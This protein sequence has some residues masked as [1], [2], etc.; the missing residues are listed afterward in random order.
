MAQSSTSTLPTPLTLLDD[1]SS[2]QFIPGQEVLVSDAKVPTERTDELQAYAQAQGLTLRVVDDDLILHDED[3]NAAIRIVGQLAGNDREEDEEDAAEATSLAGD[4]NGNGDAA[5]GG[6]AGIIAVSAPQASL[7]EVAAAGAAGSVYTGSGLSGGSEPFAFSALS[8]FGGVAGSLNSP[9]GD[10]SIYAGGGD[11]LVTGGPGN[12][13][14]SGGDGADTLSGGAGNDSLFGGAGDDLLS[15]GAGADTIS[16]GDGADTLS[17]GAGNDLLDGGAGN[18]QLSGGAG[19][20]SLSGGDGDDTLYGGPGR[21]LLDGGAG[22]DLVLGGGDADTLYG[23]TGNDVLSGGA[24]GDSLSGGEGSDTLHG[25][26]DADALSGGAGNDALSGG[27]GADTMLGGLG[28]DVLYGGAG[29]DALSGG[30]GD[31][32]V[33][34]GDDADVLAG[35]DGNDGL[36]GGQGADT[37]SGG[38][39]AD[40]LEGA[41]GR[42]VLYGG[43]GADTISGGAEADVLLGGGD[44]DML[45]GGDGNDSLTGAAGS[46]ILAGGAG[47]DMLSG[48]AGA[49]TLLS[50]AGNDVLYGGAEDDVL[51]GGEGGDGLAGGSGNDT[52]SG[53]AGADVLSG[54]I[55]HDVLLG[56][57]GQ[58]F[59][60]GGDGDDGLQG[61]G[62]ADSLFG[63]AGNDTLSGGDG[64]DRLQGAV[65]A[66]VLLGG[67]GADTLS[68]GD[69]GDLLSGGAGGDRLLGGDGADTL[70]GGLGSDTLSGGDGDDLLAGGE[71]ADA[72]DGGA[73]N[74][75]LAGG[76]GNDAFVFHLDAA[77]GQDTITD[78]ERGQDRI[79]LVG[80]DVLAAVADAVANQTLAGGGLEISIAGETV[81]LEGVASELTVADFGLSSFAISAD[82]TS[83]E[84]GTDQTIVYTITRGGDTTAAASVGIAFAGSA[85]AGEHY[86]SPGAVTV[87]FAAGETEKTVTLTLLDDQVIQPDRDITATLVAPEGGLVDAASASATTEILDDD[88]VGS[89]GDDTINGSDGSDTLSGGDGDD[90]I[91]GGDGDDVIYGGAGNDSISG[92]AGNDSVSAGDG[93]DL[94]S[95]GDGS[96]TL[97]GGL[98]DDQIGG[99][100]GD[101]VI[102]GGAGNDT[103]AG[104]GGNDTVLGGDG[105]DLLEGG[106]GNDTL[107][108]GAGFDTVLGHSGDDLLDGGA[109]GDELVGG[110]G[111]D[112][113]LGRDGADTLSGGDGADTLSGGEGADLVDGAQ[114]ADRLFGGG[115]ADTLSGAAGDDSLF[116]GGGDDLLIGGAGNDTFA[117]DADGGNDSIADFASGSDRLAFV[118]SNPDGLAIAAYESQQLVGDAV[119]VDVGAAVV[120]ILGRT[121]LLSAADFGLSTF[122]LST[123]RTTANEGDGT[124]VTYTITRGGDVG[125]SASVDLSFGGTAEAGIDYDGSGW[126]TGVQF[127]AGE[128]VKAVTVLLLDDEASD[129]EKTLTATI[130]NAEGGVLEGST[131]VDTVIVDDDLAV[132]LAAQSLTM[133]EA[134]GVG[135]LVFELTEPVAGD[136]VVRFTVGTGTGSTA[137]AGSDFVGYSGEVTIPGGSLSADAIVT[138]LDDLVYEGN[139]QFSVSITEVIGPTGVDIG[140]SGAVNTVTIVENEAAPVL[141]VDG[142]DLMMEDGSI[143]SP[144]ITI[145]KSGATDV[146]ATVRVVSSDGS[147]DQVVSFAAGESEKTLMYQPADNA[148]ADGS[149]EITISLVDATG[150]SIG[151]SHTIQVLDDE[152]IG[153]A[154]TDHGGQ[155]PDTIVGTTDDDIIRI[156]ATA[157]IAAIS[158]ITILPLSGTDY[159]EL[160]SAGTIAGT[161]VTDAGG[162]MVMQL[163][164]TGGLGTITNT[165]VS[166]GDA[167]DIVR[168]TASVGTSGAIQQT[169][170]DM[171]DGHNRVVLEAT[172]GINS[173][174]NG[175]LGLVEQLQVTAGSG[176]DRV[177]VSQHDGTVDHGAELARMTGIDLV[178]GDGDNTIELTQRNFQGATVYANDDQ[179]TSAATIADLTVTTG[180]GTDRVI[181]QQSGVQGSGGQF[182]GSHG[183][184]VRGGDAATLGDVEMFLGEG[185]DFWRHSVD[186]AVARNGS[187]VNSDG[188]TLNGDGGAAGTVDGV[189]VDFGNGTDRFEISLHDLSGG[190]GAGNGGRNGIMLSG[191]HG[192]GAGL[193]QASSVEFG[194]DGYFSVEIA[195]AAAGSGGDGAGNG[196]SAG[197]AGDAGLVSGLGVVAAGGL[198]ATIRMAGVSGGNS[199]LAQV[200]LAS[201]PAGAKHNGGS[202]GVVSDTSFSAGAG[203]APTR[204]LV[205]VTVDQA[206]GGTGSSVNGNHINSGSNTNNAGSGGL[207][208][209]VSGLDVNLAAADD[210][211][212]IAVTRSRGG[213]GGDA[214]TANAG[215]DGPQR[216]GHGGD[217]GILDQT[218]STVS[219]GD[220]DDLISIRLADNTG[221]DAGVR[222]G[223]SPTTA[224]VEMWGGSAGVVRG[225]NYEFG[226]GN[227]VLDVELTGNAV[228]A[229]RSSAGAGTAG[230]LSGLA[231]NAGDGADTLRFDISGNMSGSYGS[232]GV[233]DASSFDLGG[234]DDRL[235]IAL[236]GN[237]A[238]VDG[239]TRVNVIK[240]TT[241]VAGSGNDVV[242]LVA[243]GVA[244]TGSASVT[245]A[246]DAIT[247]TSVNLGLGADRIE[248]DAASIS[249]LSVNGGLEGSTRDTLAFVGQ[250]SNVDLRTGA[251]AL[252]MNSIEQVDLAA[253]TGSTL[254]LGRATVLQADPSG[255]GDRVL[256][257]LGEGDDIVVFDVGTGTLTEV[258]TIEEAGVSYRRFAH[259]QSGSTVY[260]ETQQGV[261]VNPLGFEQSATFLDGLDDGEAALRPAGPGAGWG[262]KPRD[263]AKIDD[264]AGMDARWGGG[265]PVTIG[266]FFEPGRLDAEGQA[267]FEAAVDSWLAKYS[268]TTGLEFARYDA[269][270]GDT[271]HDNGADIAVGIG[272]GYLAGIVGSDQV[273][274]Y[275]GI[276]MGLDPSQVGISLGNAGLTREHYA[277]A[278]GDIFLHDGLAGIGLGEGSFG[279]YVIGQELYHSLGGGELDDAALARLGLDPAAA[280]LSTVADET[281]PDVTAT[282]FA[283]DLSEFD[284]AQLQRL[285]GVSDERPGAASIA[286][287]FRA[288]EALAADPVDDDHQ[289]AIA[290]VA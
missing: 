264:L 33:L 22:N 230:T 118:G 65:G 162:A 87:E 157:S 167:A 236:A 90:E 27:G 47:D 222:T 135:S 56:G 126:T 26:E 282:D 233:V 81:R 268:A 227:D 186:G 38:G 35:G 34:G 29:A 198:N 285:Y 62:E 228:G 16:G 265:E 106:A 149:R 133:N 101:D 64:D 150:A 108:G 202:A 54:G 1:G 36:L 180:S 258:G 59:L 159:L 219:L 261:T 25:G 141:T 102:Y 269:L 179:T 252:G 78:F 182:D 10:D 185:D 169:T 183:F 85:V 119:V 251:M 137:T 184:G 160:T 241:I 125:R 238:H 289:H 177:T 283:A 122:A 115:G 136:V 266:L 244:G 242:S 43:A 215:H 13:M 234:G 19:D 267:A 103:L 83:A 286:A 104:D 200:D 170:L 210:V 151:G 71:D 105:D 131:S 57:Q 127:A 98:G 69:G 188:G 224:T 58:D 97:S 278:E 220:G 171:G 272:R 254:R 156:G 7:A 116:G 257:V 194:G 223:T 9:T 66:D 232:A 82:T 213:D 50:Q 153:L 129:G 134:A 70:S 99:G 166:A 121:E 76:A 195:D 248:I 212:A 113:L 247:G 88:S 280:H 46:D 217:A 218:G 290:S 89:P 75:L 229:G 154:S 110:L 259:T 8:S 256:R 161:T 112:V 240:D 196:T 176:N 216:T 235:E 245:T 77:D 277:T 263:D 95:G 178:L 226:G 189:V 40:L 96:D 155:G 49:D 6:V 231:M 138:L 148:I 117:L 201:M 124:L 181:T 147:I 132:R 255:G 18:D 55:G 279:Y 14:L 284:I 211:L 250:S 199:G 260:L 205:S 32:T 3:T 11:D 288:V 274:R 42:D 192:G 79:Q 120:E 262:E 239:S 206:V 270:A 28:A 111:N 174:T 48:G 143:G 128:T 271:M 207:A 2:V 114:G 4:G 72:L 30:E 45:S 68:G 163:T 94:V 158:G 175:T 253:D 281:V 60:S 91:T 164:T 152:S 17:G 139:E 15:G 214:W 24:G 44:N 31:D 204:D 243:R 23:G 63:G 53:G 140:G 209:V 84:E 20:D 193:L 107:S 123:D 276:S 86:V 187:R 172:G 41:S 237:G 146:P 92:G 225:G 73:G 52:L 130:S 197:R 61:G 273:G 142:T 51:S 191:A 168:I 190:T 275:G 5:L 203:D 67:A 249:G 144:I 287:D 93:D 145:R 221:G 246:Y 21:D 80:G 12:D 173:S 165:S 39:G 37:L 74:D 100:D 208:G 109:D